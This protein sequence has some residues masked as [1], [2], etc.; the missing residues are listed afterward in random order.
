[1]PSLHPTFRT[2]SGQNCI[3]GRCDLG[4]GRTQLVQFDAMQVMSPNA[5]AACLYVHTAHTLGRAKMPGPSPTLP[6]FWTV[7]RI[8]GPIGCFKGAPPRRY[9][10]LLTL[11][12]G[13]TKI[14]LLTRL[15]AESGLHAKKRQNTVGPL[16]PQKMPEH[17]VHF[18]ISFRPCPRLPRSFGRDMTN[19]GAATV[20][21]W[22]DFCGFTNKIIKNPF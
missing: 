12:W 7:A 22:L 15:S 8:L 6:L 14:P 20:Q 10:F 16:S 19:F 5:F 9:C 2:T 21:N 4:K 1:M 13:Y 17:P 3:F 18:P 11:L